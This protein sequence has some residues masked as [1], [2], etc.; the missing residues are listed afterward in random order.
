M[1][2]Q[3]ELILEGKL[4][5]VMWHLAWP[6]VVAMV[7]YGLNN[8]LDGIFVGHLIS[9]TA[10]AAVGIAYP[11][12]QFAQGFG[13]LIGTGIG[14][15]I[16]IWIGRK[17][18]VK[19]EQAMG[20]VNYLTL[21]FSIVLTLPCYVFAEELVYMMGGRGE[22]LTLGV[23][24]FRVT[25]LGSFFWIHGLALNMII[26][27]EGRMKTAAWMIAI[28]LL[29][30]LGLKPIFIDTLGWGVAGA[31][32]AT[33]ISMMIYTLLGVWYYASGKASFRTK[34]WSLQRKTAIIKETLSLGMPGF[35]MMVMIVIQNIV[36]FNALAKYGN[37]ADI[38]FFTAVNR[39]YILLNTP[40]WGLMRALQPVT[41]M[42][43]GAKQYTRSIQAY[44]LFS[45]VGLA[46]LLP[47]W[48]FVMVYP[49]GVLAV[50]IPHTEFLAHQLFDFR[51]YMSVL[52][53]LPFVFMAMVWF[54]A[55]EDAKPAT[56]ISLL[57]QV[58][59]Y[60][61]IMLFV[62]G[63]MGISSIYWASAAID[64]IIFALI[65]YAVS[66]SVAKLKLKNTS[67]R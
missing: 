29:V 9:N 25:I 13:T 20:T 46:I 32:W 63:I 31:A 3:K 36:V 14:S 6:A 2:K 51:I 22:I 5:K 19:L 24:Y 15:A 33:N 53:V 39:F 35:I 43:Y 26:R 65:L 4:P 18:T 47:F 62:P 8:F 50:M 57:R 30:D 64:W 42:N 41:G 48:L 11:L 1:D 23:E 10:L 21:L 67:S 17:D 16:S 12:A 49:S 54:P 66:K 34:F 27:A 60:I 45:L 38:T 37:E 52:L 59:F 58:V 28:G 55:I 56:I 7:L 40:L 44:R 61:P